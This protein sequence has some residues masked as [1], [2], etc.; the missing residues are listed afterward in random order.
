MFF[1]NLWNLSSCFFFIIRSLNHWFETETTFKQ[2]FHPLMIPFSWDITYNFFPIYMNNNLKQ[3][4]K[5]TMRAIV[6]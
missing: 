6:Q 5:K 1:L 3:K 4:S 2:A